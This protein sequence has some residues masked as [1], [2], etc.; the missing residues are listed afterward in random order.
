M[1]EQRESGG[2]EEVGR[3][4]EEMAG[5]KGRGRRWEEKRGRGFAD[6][7]MSWAARPGR[8]WLARTSPPTE[9]RSCVWME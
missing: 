4:W 1:E 3:W 8:G 5:E 7:Q 2:R 9:A 6:G